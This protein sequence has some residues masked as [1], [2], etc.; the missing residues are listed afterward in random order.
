MFRRDISIKKNLFENEGR[1]LK[2]EYANLC[3][4][5]SRFVTAVTEWV[6]V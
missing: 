4:E 2:R 1:Q 3:D 6:T 5:F